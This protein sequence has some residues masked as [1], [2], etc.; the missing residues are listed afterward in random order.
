VVLEGVLSKIRGF[1]FEGMSI[2]QE[3][4]LKNIFSQ[5]DIYKTEAV[6][7]EPMRNLLDLQINDQRIQSLIREKDS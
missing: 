1:K 7:S 3:S 5:F 6:V 4:L 2:E